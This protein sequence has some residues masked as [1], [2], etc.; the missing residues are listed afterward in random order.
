MHMGHKCRTDKIR[1]AHNNVCSSARGILSTLLKFDK[2]QWCTVFSVTDCMLTFTL[3]LCYRWS[4]CK[5]VSNIVRKIT[6]LPRF[7]IMSFIFFLVTVLNLFLYL[8]T[9]NHSFVCVQSLLEQLPQ[10]DPDY[11]YN[12]GCLLYQ[13]AKYEEACKKFM[14][15]MQLLGYVPGSCTNTQVYLQLL[16]TSSCYTIV[17]H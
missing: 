1:Q 6:L 3:S 8:F 16:Y 13:D 15:T 10:D 14:S 12:M 7:Q 2:S 17:Q 11:V 9:T 5:P 4:S